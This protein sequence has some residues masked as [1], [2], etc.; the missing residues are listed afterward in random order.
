L[1]SNPYPSP[2]LVIRVLR[3]PGPQLASVL[4]ALVTT[5][6]AVT[7]A[8]AGTGGGGLVVTVCTPLGH[9]TVLSKH[10]IV[11]IVRNDNFGRRPECLAVGT[12]RPHFRVIKQAVRYSAGGPVAFPDI[13]MGCAWGVCTSGSR[14]PARVSSLRRP[15]TS[16]HTSQ[17]AGGRWNVAY[18]I[19]FGKHDMTTNQADGAEIM[20]WLSTRG[21]PLSSTRVV[22]ID[23]ARWYLVHWIAAHNGAS[24]NYIQ[25][26]R[27]HPVAGV[28]DLQLA[29][30]IHAAERHGW[31]RPWWWLLN[32]EAGFEI[33]GGGQGLATRSFWSRA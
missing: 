23:H 1:S 17:H 10:H 33:W 22:R 5:V 8:V 7:P 14:M 20:I 24:W 4:L 15:A 29:P 31:L 3:R 32:I 21:L 2:G 6:A 25:F 9:V 26:R 16:W 12:L 11:S 28:S 18:D 30:F 13:F 19:W 27:V